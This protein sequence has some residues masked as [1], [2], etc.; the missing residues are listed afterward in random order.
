MKP[1]DALRLLA[2]GEI[3]LQGDICKTGGGT[4]SDGVLIFPVV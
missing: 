1:A 4:G 3:R 2:S